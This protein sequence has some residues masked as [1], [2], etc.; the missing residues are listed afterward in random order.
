M[1]RHRMRKV[2][3]KKDHSLART[4]KD[5]V[6]DMKLNK[7][8]KQIHKLQSGEELKYIDTTF[9]APT[10][11]GVQTLLNGTVIGT[12]QESRI[13][14]QI[15]MTSV[16]WHCRIISPNTSLGPFAYRLMIVI[17]RQPNGVAFVKSGDPLL[18]QTAL[19]NNAIITTEL[20]SFTQYEN[21]KRF[22]V[23]WDKRGAINANIGID[24]PAT[25]TVP[26]EL[27][28]RGYRKINRATKYGDDVGVVSAINTNA[29]YF[30]AYSSVTL[31]IFGGSR[32]Y[33][34]DA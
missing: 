2:K 26:M 3:A 34:K 20:D 17:D 11:A 13:A 7:I 8:E 16:M 32:I 18:G 21:S 28:F 6:Q 12:N 27:V 9:G 25:T 31:S 24:T 29:V 23:L 14:A 22:K 5:Q 10:S 15:S 1:R 30:L 4:H 33:F 19:L